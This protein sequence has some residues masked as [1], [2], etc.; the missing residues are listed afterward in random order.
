MDTKKSSGYNDIENFFSRYAAID[1][2]A[3]SEFSEK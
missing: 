3:M 2:D 1:T